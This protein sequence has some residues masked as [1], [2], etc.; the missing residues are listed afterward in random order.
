MSPSRGGSD[1][2]S[3]SFHPFRC[4]SLIRTE[5]CCV[6]RLSVDIVAALHVLPHLVRSSETPTALLTWERFFA[7]MDQNV[8]VKMTFLLEILFTLVTFVPSRTTF[9]FC[10]FMSCLRFNDDGFLLCLN[11]RCFWSSLLRLVVFKLFR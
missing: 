3:W 5:E 7:S 1:S 10:F 8:L 9:L 4:P 11:W 6:F 2:C